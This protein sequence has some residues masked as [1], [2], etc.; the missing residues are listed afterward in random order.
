MPP[1]IIP[2]NDLESIDPAHVLAAWPT[3]QPLA[4]LWSAGEPHQD[5]WTILARPKPPTIVPADSPDPLAALARTPLANLLTSPTGELAPLSPG[6][7]AL[8]SYDLGPH[9]E[10]KAPV[11][12]WPR[13][14]GA[15]PVLPRW[16]LAM[17]WRYEDALGFDRV[18]GRWWQ[19]GEGAG[20]PIAALR[21]A[22]EGAVLA[23]RCTLRGVDGQALGAGAS[24]PALA[25][26]AGA[27]SAEQYAR[28]MGRVR[29]YILAGDVYQVNLTHA[30]TLGMSGTPRDFACRLLPRAQP[31]MGALVE[32]THEGWQFALASASPELFVRWDPAS[33][34]LRTRPMKG[35]RPGH[36]SAADLA[37]STKDAAELAMIV[38]L[39]RNDLGRVCALGSVRVESASAIERHGVGEDAR[40]GLL[41][42]TATIAGNPRADATWI[43]VL[44]ACFP[45]GSITGAPKIRAMQI[46]AELEQA[47]RGPYCGALLH[48]RDDGPASASILIRTAQL[49][50]PAQ[51]AG[52]DGPWTLRWH[53]GGGIVADSDPA[54]EYAE[55]LDKAWA[56]ARTLD[57]P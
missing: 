45:G 40:P 18:T 44:R 29:E 13:A 6:T 4:V 9:L 16:P 36:A 50:R 31:W 49:T 57:P 25:R 56:L 21:A 1:K 15:A 33:R 2:C 7:I 17:L 23:R 20:V 24:G 28:V 39:M 46:I 53:V 51:P 5:R 42:A 22:C 38:D 34:T 52:A 54:R 19:L 8:L 27:W 32:A 37:Q 41:Q 12:T 35:T 47:P 10:P 30:L 55:S 26:A 11:P 48:L 3:D 14:H 43:D